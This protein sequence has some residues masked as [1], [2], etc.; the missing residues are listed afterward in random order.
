M[1]PEQTNLAALFPA[2]AAQMRGALSNLHLAAAQLAPESAREQDPRL[3]ARAAV[4][5]QSYYQLL[6]L[7]NTLSAAARLSSGLPLSLE[8]RDIVELVSEICQRAGALAPLLDLECGFP[9]PWSIISAPSRRML[10][11][12]CSIT[13]SPTPSNYPGRR[14]RHGGTAAQPGPD[15]LRVSDTGCGISEERLATLFAPPQQPDRPAPPPH[16]VGLGLSL[17]RRIA[18]AHGGTLMAESR[19]GKGSRFTLSLPDRQSGQQVQDIRFDYSGGF[20]RTLLALAD[21]LP[22]R[23]FSIRSQN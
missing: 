9:V 14:H 3:D 6:R 19:P 20:N 13:C 7:V 12:S 11:S 10:S 5:D 18:E 22:A 8:D 23:A 21:A 16:G 1:E 2:I 15:L 17:C 4:L